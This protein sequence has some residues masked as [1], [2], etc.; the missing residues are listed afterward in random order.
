[1]KIL[2]TLKPAQYKGISCDLY[3]VLAEI[4]WDT[5]T[6]L[7]WL[8]IPT[9]SFHDDIAF[10]TPVLSGLCLIGQRVLVAAWNFIT[11]IDY[12]TFQVVNAVSWPYMVDLH[13]MSTDG[14][15]VWV[16]STGIDALLCLDANKLHFKWRWGPDEPILYQDRLTT[17]NIDHGFV[18]RLPLIG[19]PIP[20][21]SHPSERSNA[22]QFIEKEYRYVHKTRTSYHYHHLNGVSFHEGFI[23]ITTKGWNRDEGKSAV[24]KLDPQTRQAEFFV[25]P[26]GFR[27]MHDGGFVDGR[28]Y[29]TEAFANSVAWR[30]PDG[31]IIS[32]QV[33]PLGYFVRGLCYT[34]S[35]LLIG[36]STWR[37]TGLP[38]QVVEYD[39]ELEH[40]LS[41]M[42]ISMFY[43]EAKQTA[44]FALALSPE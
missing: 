13:G 27:G 7:R 41:S 9:A 36:F 26:G 44:V 4:D 21:L 5:K 20:W 3:G 19:I 30:E 40:Q 15:D 43:P 16:A 18:A 11:E 35:S 39:L 24:I 6:V 38:A 2:A 1:M 10:M 33:E 22:F 12:D 23:Y 8:K 42:D 34:G 31:R 29:A 14:N 28:F 37:N 25:L 17:N 32:R